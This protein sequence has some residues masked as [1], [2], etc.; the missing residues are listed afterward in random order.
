MSDLHQHIAN[1][2]P[3][4]RRLLELLRRKQEMPDQAPIGRIGLR[5]GENVFPLSLIQQRFWRIAQLRP[6]HINHNM[7]MAL[8]LAGSL[9]EAALTAALNEIIRRHETLRTTFTT[10]HGDLV[11]VVAPA[12]TLA[13]PTTNLTALPATERIRSL[14]RVSA[15]IE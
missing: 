13:I 8:R 4:R 10:L 5:R 3:E 9:D 2:S 1:L 6:E 11:Q 12:L 7:L 15:A 14:P